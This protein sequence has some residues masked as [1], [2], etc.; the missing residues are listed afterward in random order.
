[1]NNSHIMSLCI[2]LFTFQLLFWSVVSDGTYEDP[3]IQFA[4]VQCNNTAICAF[5]QPLSFLYS[6]LSMTSC[7]TECYFRQYQSAPCVGYNY[8]ATNNSCDIFTQEPRFY[9]IE[10][11]CQY[12]QVIIIVLLEGRCQYYQV[13]IIVFST[14]MKCVNTTR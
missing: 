13:I 1:M 6:V 9:D 11:G 2:I 5:S 14:K 3:N 12:Y 8:R 7:A 4:P 10:G